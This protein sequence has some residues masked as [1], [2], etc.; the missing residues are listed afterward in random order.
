MKERLRFKTLIL[1][2]TDQLRTVTGQPTI[3]IQNYHK[4][5][6]GINCVS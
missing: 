6:E 1:G 2:Q 3:N 5:I 4:N